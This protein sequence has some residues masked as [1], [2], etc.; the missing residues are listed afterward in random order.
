[1]QSQSGLHRDSDNDLVLQH[2]PTAST[3]RSFFSLGSK[4]TRSDEPAA[5]QQDP[6]GL[7][8]L[9]EPAPEADVADL[10][11]VH[12][13]RGGSYKTWTKSNN[14]SLFWPKEWLPQ[15]EAF[16]RSRIHSFGYD[17][18]WGKGS[19]LRILDFSRALLGAMIDCPSI[20]HDSKVS[21][22]S[23][24]LTCALFSRLDDVAHLQASQIDEQHALGGI[25]PIEISNR[26]SNI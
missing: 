15:D 4:R 2:A 8:T 9:Y 17:S 25:L 19:T 10:I 1:M 22:V 5:H 6:L 24:L 14:A 20:P 7:T 18:N 23:R 13:L 26:E 3:R 21:I 16:E 12:G 11:F